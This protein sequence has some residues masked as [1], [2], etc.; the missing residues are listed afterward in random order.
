[1]FVKNKKV[2]TNLTN[3]HFI[4]AT[5]RTCSFSP[6]STF[7]DKKNYSISIAIKASQLVVMAQFNLMNNKKVNMVK[8]TFLTVEKKPLVLVVP[9]IGSLFIQ[10]RKKL[11]SH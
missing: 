8:E 6:F 1:M 5:F 4:S 3:P 7:N 2:T 11:K 9:Y 10:T